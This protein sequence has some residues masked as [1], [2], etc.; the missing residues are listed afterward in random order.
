MVWLVA[1][2]LLGAVGFVVYGV[3]GAIVGALIGLAA[4][5]TVAD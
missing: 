1:A 2:A 5:L 4:V 3:F